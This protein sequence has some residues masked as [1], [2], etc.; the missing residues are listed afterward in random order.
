MKRLILL[1]AGL[2]VG[3][4]LTAGYSDS[5]VTKEAQSASV[6]IRSDIFCIKS[7]PLAV[8]V[9]VTHAEA[10]EVLVL[11]APELGKAKTAL[12]LVLEKFR[13]EPMAVI[14]PPPEESAKNQSKLVS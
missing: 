5:S 10:C 7:Q 12:V 6:E 2:F 13:K 14:R 9:K 3:G 8:A 11:D 1:S 4:L